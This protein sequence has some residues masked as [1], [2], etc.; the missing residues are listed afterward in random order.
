MTLARACSWNRDKDKSLQGSSI[1]TPLPTAAPRE[2]RTGSAYHDLKAMIIDG[3]L[4]PGEMILEQ[5]LAERLEMSRTPVREA[6]IRLEQEGLLEIKPRRGARVLPISVDDMREI[7][8]LLTVLEATAAHAAA[9]RKLD[10][11][12]L[13]ALEQAVADM[14]ASLATEDMDAWAEADARFHALLVAASGNSRL[15]AVV[16]TMVEQSQRVRRLTLHLRPKPTGSNADHRAVV[17]AIK[18]G[19][20]VAAHDI[21]HRHRQQSGDMLVELLKRLRLTRL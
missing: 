10:P 14:D 2:K 13:A 17:E 18:S 4:V 5:E 1:D 19:D 11:N 6:L 20:A 15:M 16:A 3:R 9:K 21:H 7:Y 8:Q 12:E